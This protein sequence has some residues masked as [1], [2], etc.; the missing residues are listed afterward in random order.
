MQRPSVLN[1]EEGKYV[2]HVR[3][4]KH[5]TNEPS[6]MADYLSES[7]IVT[8]QNGLVYLTLMFNDHK[9]ITGFQVENELGEMVESIEEQVNEETNSRFEMFELER[10]TS[11]LH[12][13]VQYEVEFQGNHMKG[14]EKL[15]LA[16]DEA[17]L[18]KLD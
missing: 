1:I 3:T 9:I 13:R 16:F 5:G 6:A 7:A 10:L 2:I 18:E 14:D 17:S 8:N 12:V 4:L 11:P 15:S